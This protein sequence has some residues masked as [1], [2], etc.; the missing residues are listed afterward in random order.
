MLYQEELRAVAQS[1]RQI[2]NRVQ[3]DHKSGE[4]WVHQ[5]GIGL[6]STF[7]ESDKYKPT[8]STSQGQRIVADWHQKITLHRFLCASTH[9]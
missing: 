7:S 9:P 2:L 6:L 8:F 1:R 5:G 4:G 3:I